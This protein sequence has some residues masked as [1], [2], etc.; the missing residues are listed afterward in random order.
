[1]HNLLEKA[2][3]IRLVIFDVDGVLT[4]GTLI[5]GPQGSEYKNF[6]IYDGMGI[7]LLQKAGIVTAIITAK[8]SS[9][10]A[11][12]VQDLEIQHYYHGQEDKVI[13]YEELKQKLGLTD[14]QIAYIGDDL[15]DLPV[16]RRVGLAVSVPNA[17]EIIRKH[18]HWTTT[19]PGGKGAAR[20]LCET[21]LQAQGLLEQVLL[22][23]LQR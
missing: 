20:E 12:R 11:R 4:S 7:R 16:L 17:P 15:P 8:T 2:K 13:A 19:Q 23:Y 6:S 21:I 5:Y 3:K 18:T 10:V 1:M 22:P 9:G 14:E